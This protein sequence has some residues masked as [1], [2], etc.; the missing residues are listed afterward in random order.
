MLIAFVGL[1]SFSIHVMDAKPPT[2][3]YDL[4]ITKVA[5]EVGQVCIVQPEAP[6]YRCY[7]LT[8]KEKDPVVSI[9]DMELPPGWDGKFYNYS[10]ITLLKYTLQNRPGNYRYLDAKYSTAPVKLC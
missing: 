8:N 2:K 9:V 6:Y 7:I 3:S 10:Y 4:K 1:F 5:E